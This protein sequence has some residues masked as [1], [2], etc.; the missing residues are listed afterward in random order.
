MALVSH[1]F[2]FVRVQESGYHILFYL[3]HVGT[4]EITV[5]LHILKI[6]KHTLR[7]TTYDFTSPCNINDLDGF[8]NGGDWLGSFKLKS[9]NGSSLSRVCHCFAFFHFAIQGF[10]YL[11]HVCV[12]INKLFSVKMWFRWSLFQLSFQRKLEVK[13]TH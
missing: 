4:R 13:S 1:P 12:K 5:K 3:E 7:N 10:C 9:L 8:K 11:T 6:I 2:V